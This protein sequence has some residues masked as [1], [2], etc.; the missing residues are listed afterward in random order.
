[1]IWSLV[2]LGLLLGIGWIWTQALIRRAEA[3]FPPHGSFA[4]ID[5]VRLHFVERGEG[6]AV[7]MIHG[8]FGG[9][10]D[11]EATILPSVAESYR[12]IA[13]DRPGHGYSERLGEAAS[14][15]AQAR[16]IHGL[17]ADLGL[18][19]PLLVGFSWGATTSLAYALEFPDEV[20][21]LVLVNGAYYPWPGGT[22]PLF[23][24]PGLP[25]VGPLLAHTVT[26]PIGQLLARYLIRR[27]FEPGQ[28]TSGFLR[29]SPVALAMRPQSYIHNA[30]D[31]RRLKQYLG[32]LSPRWSEI[33]IPVQVLYGTG[34]QVASPEV[35]SLALA[36]V[37]SNAELRPV[38]RGGHQV[39]YTH[40]QVVRRAIDACWERIDER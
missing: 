7:V 6:R 14:P 27:A 18:E 40:P 28:P 24:I 4:E 34:D 16:R 23:W 3:Q 12:A 36:E 30:D 11:W 22:S 8:A 21:G 15:T 5:G 10:H 29:H 1:M 33:Q 31:M 2:L 9:L 26:M 35:H 32:E 38:E 17:L 39:P 13:V 19:R 25:V 20:A 37:L